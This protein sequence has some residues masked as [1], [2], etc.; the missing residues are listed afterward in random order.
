MGD[1]INLDWNLANPNAFAEGWQQARQRSMQS[2]ADLARQDALANPADINAQMRFAAFDPQGSQSVEQS[3]DFARM[4]RA[5]QAAANYTSAFQQGGVQGSQQQAS[6]LAGYDPQLLNQL[7]QTFNLQDEGQRARV[8]D[9]M[10][11]LGSQAQTLLNTP[12]AQ[13]AATLQAMAPDLAQHGIGPD[14]IAQFIQSGLTDQQLQGFVR[15]ALGVAG[16]LSQQNI[17]FNQGIAQQNADSERMNAQTSAGQLALEMHKPVSVGISD[18]LVDPI[19]HQVVYDPMNAGGGDI[20]SKIATVEGTTKNPQSSANGVG[21]F[22]NAT[23]RQ[24][25]GAVSPAVAQ[26][27][28]GMNDAQ[29]TQWR[30]QNAATLA[31]IQ[32]QML[33]QLTQA[34]QQKLT[35]AGLPTTDANTYMAHVFGAGG[36]VAALKADPNAPAAQFVGGKQALTNNGLPANATVSQVQAWAAQKMQGAGGGGSAMIEGQAQ[37]IARGDQAPITGRA[38]ASGIGARIMQRVYQINPDYD[39]KMFH[40]EQ[41]AL[42]NFLGGAN[43]NLV[44]SMSV[45]MDHLNTLGAA[46]LALQN[47]DI[48]AFNHLGQMFATATGSPAPTNFDA[49]KGIVAA[50]VAK[51]ISGAQISDSR[52]ASVEAGI[53]NASS[54]QQLKGYIQQVQALIAGQLGGLQRQ[55]QQTTG[56]QDFNRFLSPAAQQVLGAVNHSTAPW[57]GSSPGGLGQP[58]HGAIAM[59]QANPS[60]RGAFDAKYGAGAAA[61]VL[62]Q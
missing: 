28:S 10:Q 56:K 51:A 42:D 33:P 49:T 19:T 5:R 15:D 50:E 18:T 29:L 57:P 54:P 8:A 27:I 23:F 25:V 20:N 38:S 7:S 35:S 31:P 36:T 4:A 60:L 43:A 14:K 22:T 12:P 45:S 32:Q 2:Q 30:A 47:G 1:G 53:T 17:Q 39:S 37:A 3:Q 59:L 55:Y 11:F 44:R 6:Q 40:G 34:N 46:S 24:Y 16:T 9:S 21:Q 13:R 62:G 26:Q 58:P 61:R 52:V 41:K 48:R